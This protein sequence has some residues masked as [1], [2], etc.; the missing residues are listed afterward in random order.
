MQKVKLMKRKKI[1]Q[2]FYFRLIAVAVVVAFLSAVLAFSL[3]LLTEYFQHH[4][5]QFASEK[6]P[7]LFIVLPTVGITYIYFS[8]KYLFKNRKNKGI[9]EIYKTIDQRK[10]HLPF[11][12][13]PSHYLNGFLTVIF[14]G[15]TGIEV[16][17]VV[18]AATVGNSVYN[19]SFSANIYKLELIGA[20]VCAGVAVLFNSP[21][22]GWLFAFEVIARKFN[23]SLFLSFTAAAMVA[24]G[25]LYLFPAEPI[26]PLKM[27]DWQWIALPFIVILSLL[28][29]LLSAYFTLLV[30]HIKD[31]FAGIHNNFIRVNL[32]ALAVGTLICF[33]P[34]LYGDSYHSLTD[35][36][37]QP[38]GYSVLFLFGLALLKPVASSLTL[39]A[40]GDVGVFAPSIVAGAYLGLGFAM[41]CNTLFG[42]SLIYINF[43]LIGAAAT[44]STSIYAPFTAL[45]LVCNM[46]PGGFA[47]TVPI[48]LACLISKYFTKSFILPY[49]VYT[50]FTENSSPSK[51]V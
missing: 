25:F 11:F 35:I 1:Q 4:I 29:G 47:L 30:I 28:S 40:G 9:A 26:L 38:Q 7:L 34:F 36:F 8:R 19:K 37:Q 12:K 44:L 45:F 27:Q 20:G 24:W 22:A 21:V 2:H 13:I 16:S 23:R 32:G 14:G 3:K 10:E 15:S 39:G 33:F 41:V 18:A 5:F 43:A 49:N 17:T 46:V 48:L 6:N 31:F 42:T 51:S 50:Y